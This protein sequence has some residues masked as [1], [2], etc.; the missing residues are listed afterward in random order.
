MGCQEVGVLIDMHGWC[1]IW[2][3]VVVVRVLNAVEGGRY[4]AAQPVK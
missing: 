3:V 1:I 4:L 2:S